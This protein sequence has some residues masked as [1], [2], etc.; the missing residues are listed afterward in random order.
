MKTL[1]SYVQGRWHIGSGA[2][3]TLYNPT[4][5]EPLASASSGGIDFRAVLE[6]ARSVGGPA[7]RAMTF[8]QRAE[9]LDRLSKAIHA[10][11]DE[12]IEISIQNAGTTRGDA[13]FDIDGAIGTLAAYA[14]TG[15]EL[16]AKSFLYDGPGV[17][18]GRTARFWGEHVLVPR[19]GAAVHVNAFNFPAW[20]MMEKAACALLAGAPVIEKPGTPTALLAWRIAELVVASGAVPEGGYQFIAG[21]VGDLLDHMTSQDSLAFTGSS[22]T[23]AKLRGHGQLVKHNV[24]VNLEADSLNA[25]VLA[26]D[27]EAGSDTFNLFVANVAL[28]MAQKTGQKCTAV[29]RVLVPRERVDELAAEIQAALAAYKVG[30]P[31]DATTRMGPL[32]SADQLRDVR[33]GIERLAKSARSVCGGAAPIRDK[34]YFVAPT[35]FVAPDARTSV[36]H[37][38]EVFGPVATILPYAGSAREAVELVGLGGGSLVTSVYSND[39][40]FLE[41]AALGIGAWSGRVWLGSDKMAEQALAPG[42]VLPQMIHGGPGRAGGGEELGALRG[43]AFY[44][45]RVALQ[46]FKGVIAPESFALAN[47]AQTRQG[48]GAP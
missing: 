6:H 7:L 43:L 24:R 2:S 21:S 39:V 34:G 25:A 26:P 15:A 4:T 5:E 36:V 47:S 42:M 30:D 31:A 35:L 29:R 27:V 13:K 19:L 16:G 9:M 3:A 40:A 37:T 14:R 41:T 1:A 20:N 10:H 11:R 44:L 28:D 23:A 38:D 12:L 45:Q 48:A 18:L 22:H 17:Q 46:G 8:G 32:A 33:A